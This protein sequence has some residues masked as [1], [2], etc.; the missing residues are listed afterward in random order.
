M[1][2]LFVGGTGIISTA[3][4]AL[5]AERGVDLTVATRGTRGTALPA[6]VEP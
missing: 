2:V 4:T 1:K 3:C 6:G 5:L